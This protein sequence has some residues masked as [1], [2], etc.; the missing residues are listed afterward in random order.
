MKTTVKK[1][2]DTRVK[3]T[4][5]L[6]KTE[7][8]KAEQVAL[9][10]LAKTMK[11]PG[12]RKGHV[13]VSVAAK[14]ADPVALANETVD[15][16]LSRAVA[17]AFMNEK[18]Q[19]LARPEVEVTKFVPAQELEF[20][21][22][23]DVLPEVKL[24]N[25]KKLGIK[26]EKVEISPSEVSEIIE[27]LRG[28]MATKNEVDRAAK[29]GD[30]VVIDFTGKK[31]GVAFEGGT[32]KDY[33]LELGS[34]SFIPGFE[35]GLVG[36]KPGDSADLKLK[37][38]ESYHVADLAGADVVFETKLHKVL[39][40]AL[41][42]LNDEF[43]AKTGNPEITTLKDLKADIKR[44]LLAQKERELG[45]KRKD[46]LVGKLVEVSKVPVPEVLVEDQIR[47][48]EQDMLQNLMYQNITLDDYLTAQKFADKEEW[49]E[50]EVKPAATKRV[51]AGLVLAELSKEL[52]V[53]ATEDEVAEHV[54]R[55][56]QSY[57]NNPEMLKRFDEPEVVRDIANRLVTE[58]TV[59]ALVKEN[60]K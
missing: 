7:L 25:Y 6:G 23:V 13:P 59:D 55:Y 41:P 15:N 33:S 57:A 45:E 19:V 16:A 54:T 14:H 31:D 1:L 21:A 51:Q 20:T 42:E 11:V 60:E 48:I 40:K 28:S 29:N 26:A 56:K 52:K 47:S 12:F 2:T 37:F 32:A 30:E 53:G 5:A 49:I 38:P 24:G 17:E 35:E 18:L 58:K 39:E 46:A 8:N 4:V 9:T 10:K 50:K 27:R 44:E 34:N 43:A 36:K 3:L 22:E